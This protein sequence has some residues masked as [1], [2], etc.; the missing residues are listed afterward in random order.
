MKEIDEGMTSR[1]ERRKFRRRKM[2]EQKIMG[3]ICLLI[4]VVILIVASHTQTPDDLDGTPVF[5]IAPL[6]FYLI[7]SKECWIY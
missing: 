3:I 5:F 1:E 4:C 2:I 6:G 7:F